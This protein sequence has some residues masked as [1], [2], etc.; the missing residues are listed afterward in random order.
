MKKYIN[1]LIIACCAVV[2]YSC[3][4]DTMDDINKNVNDP[5]DVSSSLIITEAMTSSAFSVTGSD[6]AF[7]S[8]VY[9]EHNVGV[10][11][12]MYNA[13]IRSNEPQSSTTYNNSWN[14]IYQNLLNLKTIIEKCSE[15]GSEEGNFHTLGIAQTLTAYNLAILTDVMGDVPWTE[16]LQPGVIFTPKLDKQ[17]D[18]YNE[19]F[20]LLDNATTNLAKETTFPL[21][22]KQDFIYGGNAASIAK[23]IKFANGLKARYTMRLSHKSADY[24]AVISYANL[25]FTNASEQC[26]FNYN[27]TTTKSPFQ[28]FFLDRDYFGASKSFHD[29]LVERNDPRDAIL[30]KPYDEDGELLFAPNGS[31]NQAQGVY[32]I[33]AISSL[34]AP[35]YLLSYHEVEFLKA[36]AFA[37]KNELDDAKDALKNAIIAAC[38]KDNIGISAED[39]EA[40]YQD[41]VLPLL[42]DQA[43][44]LKEIMVQKYIAFFEEEAVEAYNDIRRLKAMGNDFIKID[45]PLKFPLRFT[46]GSEDVTTNENVRNAYGDG[47]YVYTENVW[48]AGGTR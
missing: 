5:T 40:Y 6:L 30:F 1:K 26:E 15:G 13:E 18:I 11:N 33:S 29:K 2:V 36:E 37:R 46:Y 27:G 21:L 23:W 42:T 9:V 17:E 34:T 24:D 14:S 31:P 48:W 41:E 12:Q 20:T 10:Y 16:A 3:S 47:T 39:A 8:S 35:T 7:Y 22:G 28:Q 38:G 44:T 25:S 43:A 19:I 4:E 32:A 45:N